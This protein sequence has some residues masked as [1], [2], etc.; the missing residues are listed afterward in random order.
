MSEAQQIKEQCITM[1]VAELE[2]LMNII[3]D[4]GY[5]GYKVSLCRLKGLS[6]GRCSRNFKI[7]KSLAQYYWESCQQKG[8]DLHLKRM[9]HL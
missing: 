4:L 2:L 9:F 3:G 6:Y 1:A 8:Y 5:I 7:K